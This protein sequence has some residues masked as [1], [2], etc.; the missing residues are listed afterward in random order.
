MQLSAAVTRCSSTSTPL[1]GCMPAT[2]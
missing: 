1:T 2:T